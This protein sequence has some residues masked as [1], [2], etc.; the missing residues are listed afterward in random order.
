MLGQSVIITEGVP[1]RAAQRAPLEEGVIVSV[2]THGFDV[3][4][5]VPAGLRRDA[6]K[7]KQRCDDAAKRA[8]C[9]DALA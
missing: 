4:T 7:L 5:G 6:K 3:A 8:R 9:V 2:E 1:A